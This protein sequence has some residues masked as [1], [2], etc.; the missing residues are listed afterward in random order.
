MKKKRSDDKRRF[1]RHRLVF[2]IFVLLWIL[3]LDAL[4]LNKV[5]ENQRF[6]DYITGSFI[7]SVDIQYENALSA[8]I[9]FDVLI[10]G[11][12]SMSYISWE[13]RKKKLMKI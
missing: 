7:R 13:D 11:S 6:Q 4:I 2:S 12:F 10:A 9:L 1:I 5:N 3:S 8:M